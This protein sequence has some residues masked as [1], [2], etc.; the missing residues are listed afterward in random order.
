VTDPP[1]ADRGEAPARAV[2]LAAGSAS[3]LGRPKSLQMWRGLAALDDDAGAA[4]VLLAD[5][6][7]VTVAAVDAVVAAWRAGAGHVVRPRYRDAP[8]DLDTW[9]DYRA[10][11]QR[12]GQG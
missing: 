10:L 11:L 12:G 2:V 9:A 8:P 7:T 6:P 4:V 1:S 3:R 5:Q